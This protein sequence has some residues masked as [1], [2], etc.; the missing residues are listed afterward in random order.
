[1][2][3]KVAIAGAS[4][5][6]GKYLLDLMKQ[7]ELHFVL[8]SRN[9]KEGFIQ[10][11]YSKVDL[12]EKLQGCSALINLVGN[13]SQSGHIEAYHAS[14]ISIQN[15]YE[16]C[17]QCG[18]VNIVY[19][20]S[21]SVYSDSDCLPWSE[22]ITPV[23]VSLYGVS[24]LTGE[25][26]GNYFSSK[27]GLRVKNL[28]LAHLYG[29]NEKNNYMINLFFRQALLG[30]CIKLNTS[31]TSKREFLYAK[32]AARYILN[33]LKLTDLN[34]TYNVGSSI[35]LTNFEVAQEINGIF[36][37]EGGIKVQNPQEIDNVLPSYMNSELAKKVGIIKK[38]YSFDESLF[39]IECE[40]RNASNIQE[41]Y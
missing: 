32:D 15:L 40:M 35:L 36:K 27:Y 29:A 24:K 5:I 28:R 9:A 4:G 7:S 33:S 10:T 22:K 1:M 34:G 19:A 26:L 8:L 13:R 25:N 20:S 23:P 37:N 3:N 12:I 39:E 17:L 38:Q 6:L 41:F 18:I 14:E 30:K 21:I 31:S 16:A 11:D 2:K